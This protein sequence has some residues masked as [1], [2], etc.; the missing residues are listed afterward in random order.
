MPVITVEALMKEVKIEQLLN[1]LE[2]PVSEVLAEMAN[3]SEQENDES[4]ISFKE[5]IKNFNEQQ[6]SKFNS[7]N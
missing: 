7:Q 4:L 5:S 6:E 3:S 2:N 1:D